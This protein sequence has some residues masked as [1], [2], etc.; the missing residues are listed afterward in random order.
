VLPAFQQKF[1]ESYRAAG[2][3][4]EV[5]VFEDCD[6]LWVLDPGPATERAHDMVK[7][8]IARQ[9]KALQDRS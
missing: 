7:A 8:F 1:G 4:C 2:G 5:S 3:E 9:L 6:H